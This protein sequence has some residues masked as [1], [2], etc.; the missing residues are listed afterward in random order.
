VQE[1]LNWPLSKSGEPQGSEGSNPSL[2]AKKE[3]CMSQEIKK[4][5]IITSPDSPIAITSM[6][7]GAISI[8]LVFTGFGF[9]FGIPAIITS[10]IALKKKRGGRA[11]SMTGLITGSISTAITVLIFVFY[12]CIGMLQ[13]AHPE[14]FQPQPRQYLY[15]SQHL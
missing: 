11:L 12:T 9:I 1:W 3:G 2:S 10:S 13:T 8:A 15:S 5:I 4:E 14:Y 6:V 7:L